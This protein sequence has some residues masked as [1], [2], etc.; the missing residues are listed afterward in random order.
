MNASEEL[1][2]MINCYH[3]TQL[4]A[5]KTRQR[6]SVHNQKVTLARRSEVCFKY[7]Q[8]RLTDADG[9]LGLADFVMSNFL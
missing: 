3:E 1:N 5:F 2:M 7:A 4:S 8:W 9:Q 6:A